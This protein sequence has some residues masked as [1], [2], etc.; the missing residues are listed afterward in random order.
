MAAEN[1]LV[2]DLRADPKVSTLAYFGS[3]LRIKREEAGLSQTTLAKRTFCNHSLISRIESAER[4]P[5]EEFAQR[6]DEVLGTGGTF[7]RL[8]PVVIQHAYPDWFRPFVEM[9]R[10][11]KS[12]WTFENQVVP[13]LL[14]T[15]EYA[16]AMFA[17][18]RLPNAH[19]LV[20]ARMT[21]QHILEE[22]TPPEVWAILDEN[23]LRRAIGGPEVMRRQL[24]RLAEFAQEPRI[25]LQVLPYAAGAHAGLAGD[26][27]GLTLDEGP[28]V[29]Y[30]D[31]IVRGH[32]LASP[33]DVQAARRA[34]DLLR[35]DALSPRASH[36]MI[37]ATAKEL[38]A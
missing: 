31:G 34:Y 37:A 12:I 30:V 1:G 38:A 5:T 36:D 14:Q 29:V 10:D 32:I 6:C 15:E 9:E 13:G 25:V 11:A 16:K 22:E 26:F 17:P 33:D 19:E 20:A 8:W 21:R 35:A 4:V 7:W 24:E 23:V 3:E 28:D 18:S 2:G 27:A